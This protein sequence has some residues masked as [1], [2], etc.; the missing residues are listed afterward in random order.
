MGIELHD[1]GLYVVRLVASYIGI[2][3]KSLFVAGIS[4]QGIEY[5]GLFLKLMLRAPETSAGKDANLYTAVFRRMIDVNLRAFSMAAL[6]IPVPC[7]V[8]S[9]GLG[10]PYLSESYVGGH[11]TSLEVQWDFENR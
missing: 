9:E 6:I 10:S 4:C 11:C 8:S 1:D 3:R 2:G 7:H 5:A